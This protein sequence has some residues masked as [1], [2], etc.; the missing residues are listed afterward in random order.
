MA[1]GVQI[2]Y[3]DVSLEQYDEVVEIMGLLPVALHPRE[4]FFIA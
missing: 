1:V 3:R 4:S 2:D